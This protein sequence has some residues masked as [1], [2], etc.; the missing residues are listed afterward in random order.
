MNSALRQREKS[1][2]LQWCLDGVVLL[3]WGLENL[4]PVPEFKREGSLCTRYTAWVFPA[5][6]TYDPLRHFWMGSEMV[7]HDFNAASRVTAI[8][9]NPEFQHKRW[10]YEKQKRFPQV[11][12]LA[13]TAEAKKAVQEVLDAWGRQEMPGMK[14]VV[15]LPGIPY[16]ARYERGKLWLRRRTED[17]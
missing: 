5:F 11:V 17:G 9:D 13:S 1:E 10:V 14:P 3:M 16:E 8:S 15:Q 7:M 6:E 12:D 2:R 4:P